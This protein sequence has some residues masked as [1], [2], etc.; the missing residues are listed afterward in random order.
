MDR[1]II[2]MLAPQG[3]AVES[4]HVFNRDRIHIG[5]AYSSDVIVDDLFVS[6]EHLLV[7]LKEGKVYLKDLASK[8]GTQVNGTPNFQDKIVSVNSGDV[9]GIG[10]TRFRLLLP[11]HPVESTKKMDRFMAFRDFID[12]PWVPFVFSL[13]VIGVGAWMGR[14]VDPSDS[15]WKKEFYSIVIGFAASI[16]SFAG[17]LSLYTFF[18]YRRSYFI[19]NLVIADIGLFLGL[20][21]E[22]I[23]PFIYFWVLNETWVYV[24]DYA[25]N[26]IITLGMFW[27]SVRLAKDSL[28]WGETFGLIWVPLILV[29]IAGYGESSRQMGFQNDP[30]YHN[31]LAPGMGPL[32]QPQTLDEFLNDGAQEFKTLNEE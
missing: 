19:R 2:E 29:F 15:F 9:I 27:A 1:I 18:K 32:F 3:Q 12:R 8:N 4:R 6:P 7:Q 17:I 30:I 28:T 14:M 10:R 11:D 21:L 16:L 22:G 13:A 25:I 31:K 20:I 26:F 23:D 24:I 5:R